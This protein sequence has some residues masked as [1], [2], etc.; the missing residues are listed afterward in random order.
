LTKDRH[1]AP[2]SELSGNSEFINYPRQMGAI[3]LEMLATRDAAISRAASLA[4]E[5]ADIRARAEAEAERSRTDLGRLREEN[6]QIRGDLLGS[7]EIIREMRRS[8]SWKLTAPIRRLKSL[9][10][11]Q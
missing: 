4:A 6:D 7:R 8:K 2:F 5:T 3:H 11:R 9:L 1:A 10:S